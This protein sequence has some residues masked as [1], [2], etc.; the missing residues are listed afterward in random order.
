MQLHLQSY[1]WLTNNGILR[2]DEAP[3]VN[4]EANMVVLS[5]PQAASFISGHSIAAML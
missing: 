2:A 4:L 1:F 5:P 3:E